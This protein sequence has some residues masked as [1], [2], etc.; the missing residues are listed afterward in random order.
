MP[1]VLEKSVPTDREAD[2]STGGDDR[3]A[4]HG[5]RYLDFVRMMNPGG[6]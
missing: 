2:Y 6:R 5:L 3:R 1:A 4:D